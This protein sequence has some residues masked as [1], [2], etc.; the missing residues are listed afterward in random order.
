MVDET[1]DQLR[2]FARRSRVNHDADGEVIL[3]AIA[4]QERHE[5]GQQH[6]FQGT[7]KRIRD[8]R[9]AQIPA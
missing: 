9:P 5:N 2:I 1:A 4:V 8:S 6:R 3:A 7:L